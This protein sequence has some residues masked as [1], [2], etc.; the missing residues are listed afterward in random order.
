[1]PP[2]TGRESGGVKERAGF[3]KVPGIVWAAIEERFFSRHVHEDFT[4]GLRRAP[5]LHGATILGHG[6]AYDYFIGML[7]MPKGFDL[8]CGAGKTARVWVQ[9]KGG[10]L[11]PGQAMVLLPLRKGEDENSIAGYLAPL[12]DNNDRH[13]NASKICH[14]LCSDVPNR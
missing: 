10:A 4:F 6:G 2:V 8:R 13:V 1:M 7:R 3:P 12:I 11:K 9:G 5:S 14:R